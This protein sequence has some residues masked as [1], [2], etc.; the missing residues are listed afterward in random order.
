MGGGGG[1][2]SVLTRRHRSKVH[3]KYQ[4]VAAH[5][6]GG[7]RKKEPPAEVYQGEKSEPRIYVPVLPV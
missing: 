3:Q 2:L 5:L 4:E 7:E 6:P 1:T